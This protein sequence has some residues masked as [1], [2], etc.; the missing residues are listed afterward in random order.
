MRVE[1]QR[2]VP[3]LLR[4]QQLLWQG[5]QHRVPEHLLRREQL[6][7]RRQRQRREQHHLQLVLP[8]ELRVQHLLLGGHPQPEER[9]PQRERHLLRLVVLPQRRVHPPQVPH[10][11]H[12]RR[13]P[14]VPRAQPVAVEWAPLVVV[15]V[16]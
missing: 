4:V 5:Q 3:L 12:L 8:Q 11:Q 9:L 13:V 2:R 16:V 14:V 6:Q 15:S 7:L 1:H 10:P